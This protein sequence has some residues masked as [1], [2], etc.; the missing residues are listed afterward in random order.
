MMKHKESL[1]NAHHNYLVNTMISPGFVLGEP[2]SRDDFYFLADLVPLEESEPRISAYLF[3][4]QG[5]FILEL[6]RNKI[7]KNPGRCSYK[8]TP[9]GFRLLYPSEEL[10]LAVNTQKFTNGYIT[11]IQG[12]LYDMNG[13]LRM[14]PSYEDIQVYGEACLSLDVP[15]NFSRR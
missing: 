5:S 2:D 11:R 4:S 6:N 1:I 3:D 10:L 12:K 9:G 14:E 13:G 8:T 15:F 7:V